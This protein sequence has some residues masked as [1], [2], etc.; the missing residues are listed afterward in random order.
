MP[1]K[2]LVVDDEPDVKDL[3]QQRF[4]RQIE[5]GAY[6]F[7]FAYNGQQ[8][9]TLLQAEPDFDVL[10]LDLNMPEMD[11][12]TLLER[13][14]DLLPYGRAVIV[15]A[16]D[17]MTNIRAAMNRGA[18]DFVCKPINFGDLHST[19]E[20]TARH[21]H[22]LRELAQAKLLAELKARFFDNITHEFRT[23]LTLIL[24]PLER[25]AREY[26]H[27]AD[28]RRDLWAIEY[29]AQYLLRLINQLLELA[30]LEDGQVTVQ[31]LPGH[32]PQLVAEVVQSFAP[33]AAQQGVRLTGHYQPP[34]AGSWLYDADIIGRIVYNLLANALKFTPAQRVGA[35]GQVLLHLAA[36]TS[37]VQLTITDNG[38]GIPAASLPYI[39]DRFYQTET[40]GLVGTGLGLALVKELTELLGGRVAVRSTLATATAAGG[41]T[42]TVEL[43]LRLAREEAA[44]AAAP[45]RWPLPTAPPLVVAEAAPLAGAPLLLLV[46]DNPELLAYLVAEL[47]PHYRLLTATTG[48]QAWE[49]AQ[50]ELPDL[51]L[52]DV[53]LPGLDGYELTRL[54]KTTPSTDHLAVVLLTAKAAYESRLAGLQQG[55]DD[56]LPKPFQLAELKLRLHNLLS[57]QQRLRDFYAQQLAQL[58]LPQPLETVH[59]SWLRTLYTILEKHLDDSSLSVE[60]LAGQLA[61]SRKTLLR[62]V[63]ALTQLA[64]NE[65]IRHY[66][67]RK[68]ADLLRAGHQVAETAYLVGFETPAYFGQCFKELYQL[69]PR[70]F[71]ESARVAPSEAGSYPGT[72]VS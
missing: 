11:G 69:T 58:G 56:Y 12:L 37:P 52:S 24:L 71:R 66:R 31:P 57:R 43:P 8:A 38:L 10:L 23:P 15:S 67:L 55:A 49:L 18:Y 64:P 25:L 53:M 2:I 19:I 50:A 4:Y 9:L 62:K 68:A 3:L 61:M 35:P 7:Q 59:D 36:E 27:A 48:P 5:Q 30:K 51:V 63:Q 13:L 22:Q 45:R 44:P 16:Y 65:L 40:T 17:D 41:T 33:L 6:L 1:T 60:W 34:A 21:A 72:R 29:N 14:P 28:A 47:A 42:F 46:E 70:E 20:K 54:L 26:G 32:L 39:F